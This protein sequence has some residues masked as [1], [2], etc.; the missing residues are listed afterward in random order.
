LELHAQ[1]ASDGKPL[2]YFFTTPKLDFVHL[3][4]FASQLIGSEPYV[5]FRLKE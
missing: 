2:T 3:S 1:T 4:E 5:L